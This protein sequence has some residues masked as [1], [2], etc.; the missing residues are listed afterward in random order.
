MNDLTSQLAELAAVTDWDGVWLRMLWGAGGALVSL[1]SAYVLLARDVSYIKG[2][3]DQLTDNNEALAEIRR[4]VDS[5]KFYQEVI[6]GQPTATRD[7]A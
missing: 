7:H 3:L 4:D 5:I 1:L 2:K 6:H